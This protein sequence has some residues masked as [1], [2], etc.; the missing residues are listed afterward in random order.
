MQ[1]HNIHEVRRHCEDPYLV[2]G[3]NHPCNGM[4]RD[5]VSA[6]GERHSTT[7]TRANINNHL[8]RDQMSSPVFV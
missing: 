7:N 3:L 8:K 4:Y 2:P 6:S 5:D 1:Q